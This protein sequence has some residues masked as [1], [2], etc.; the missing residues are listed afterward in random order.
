M[1]EQLA[2]RAERKFCYFIVDYVEVTVIWRRWQLIDDSWQ[3]EEAVIECP[4]ARACRREE[5]NCTC[6]YPDSGVD[7]FVPFKDLLAEM[8]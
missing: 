5:R 1:N 3:E 4:K 6:I 2:R 8:W 7:P